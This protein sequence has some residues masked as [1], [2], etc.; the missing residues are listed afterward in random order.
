LILEAEQKYLER[1]QHFVTKIKRKS[2][3]SFLMINQGNEKKEKN[4]QQFRRLF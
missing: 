3:T 2:L 4:W 1:K